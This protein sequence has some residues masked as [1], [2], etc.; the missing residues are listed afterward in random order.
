VRVMTTHLEYYSAPIRRAQVA[1][2]REIHAEACA[3]ARMPR[4]GTGESGGSFEVLPRPAS[5]LLCGDMNFPARAEERRHLLAPYGDATVTWRDSW[6]LLHPGQPHGATVGIH[7]VDF[8]DRPECY[9]FVFL[10]EDL[11]PRLAGQ[12]IDAES[13]ASDH[14]PVWVV[15]K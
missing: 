2:I 9:D 12:G 11:A 8:V 13:E 6:E 14:Q 4:Q 5:A 1:A 15:L 7:P 10:T 3:H